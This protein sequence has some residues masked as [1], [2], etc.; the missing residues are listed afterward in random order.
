[1]EIV[2]LIEMMSFAAVAIGVLA[3]WQGFFSLSLGLIGAACSSL[4]TV[5][6]VSVEVIS[7]FRSKGLEAEAAALQDSFSQSGAVIGLTWILLALAA[8]GLVA[9]DWFAS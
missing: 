4:L 9:R 1:M 3:G 7:I 8:A 5:H 6:Y 2:E